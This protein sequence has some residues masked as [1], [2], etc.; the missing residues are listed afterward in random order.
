NP[1]VLAAEHGQT[2]TATDEHGPSVPVSVSPCP[3]VEVI[4]RD[5][6]VQ[7]LVL[8]LFEEKT[9]YEREMLDLDLD[10]EADLGID[11]IKQA[12]IFASVR[13]KYN[14]PREEG[15]R[16]KDFPTLRKVIEYI[17]RRLDASAQSAP[18]PL[19]ELPVKWSE[20]KRW[21]VTCGPASASSGTRVQIQPGSLFLLTDD[22]GGFAAA[23]QKQLSKLG[24]KSVLLRDNLEDLARL[25][26]AV[27]EVQRRE[28][29]I[30][31]LIH[32][33][34]LKHAKP[35][36][37]MDL[38]EWRRSTAREIKSLLVLAKAL[39]NQPAA[40]NRGR[41]FAATTSLGGRFGFPAS[42]DETE[43]LAGPPTHGGV[44]G[45]IK[46]LSKEAPH[47]L[48]KVIDLSRE[49]VLRQPDKLAS[50]VLAEILSGDP[51]LEVGIRDGNRAV[52]QISCQPVDLSDETGLE[53]GRDSV[54]V[55]FGGA[56]GITGVI[57][58]DLAKLFHCRLILAGT[59]KLN[60]DFT[61]EL[62]E[63]SGEDLRRYRKQ[64][65]DEM[66]RQDPAVTPARAEAELQKRLRVAEIH[67]TLN[68]IRSEAAEVHY[69]VCDVRDPVAMA[70]LFGDLS[71][72]F[73][74]L[75]GVVFAA[76]VIED[77]LLEEKTEESFSRVFDVKADGAFNLYGAL[78]SH[79]EMKPS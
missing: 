41:F 34:P 8:S 20:I 61:A 4:S 22:D 44:A 37:Q 45:F 42:P 56:R 7:E 29:P 30:D 74:R 62:A 1:A 23:I 73:G 64:V 9:G 59:T 52:P 67:R 54:L 55:L 66:R 15:V 51:A 39:L 70:R 76:G 27:K 43:I 75:D 10:L 63:L 24:V 53:L 49:E 71:T 68:A 57:A 65:F 48:T 69:E 78:K 18:A 26:E 77:K 32:L 40:G 3:S 11:T 79:P 19:H 14:L 2:R 17:G 33:L 58:Q 21:T 46:A 50:T 16:L 5:V 38:A 31:G 13:D 12:Q 25:Q 60:P 6:D 72:R 35:I 28:G 47:F 36:E